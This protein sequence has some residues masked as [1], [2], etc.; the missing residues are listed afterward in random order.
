MSAAGAAPDHGDPGGAAPTALLFTGG[1]IYPMASPALE[2]GGALLTRG[3]RV[4][5]VG[6]AEGLDADLARG[7]APVELG[8]RALLPGLCDGHMHLTLAAAE[9]G[10][11]SL[12]G[13]R[14]RAELAREVRQAAAPAPAGSWIRGQGWEQRLLGQDTASLRAALDAA[15]PDHPVF[16]ASKD[17]HSVLLNSPALAALLSGARLPDKC[18]VERGQGGEPTGLVLE[19][20]FALRELLLPPASEAELLSNLPDYLGYLHA[21]GITTAHSQEEPSGARLLRRYLDAAPVSGRA[22]VLYNLLLQEPEE[23][24]DGA[25]QRRKDALPG[26][27]APG[28]YKLFLDGTFGTLS[29]AVSAPYASGGGRG[30]LLMSDEELGRWLTAIRESGGYA[31]MHAIGDRAVDQAL[32]GVR[33]LGWPAGTV[34]R[35]EHAQLV[36][37]AVLARTGALRGVAISGQPSH[38]WGDREIVARHLTGEPARRYAYAFASVLKAGAEL[39]FGSDAPVEQPDPWRGVQAALTRMDGHQDQGPWIPG[40]RLTLEQC[41]RAHTTGPARL[42]GAQLGCGALRAG[43]LADLVVL[44]PDPFEVAR[45]DPGA[46]GARVRAAETYLSGVRVHPR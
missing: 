16:L 22:R 25:R 32:Q 4:A 41:L 30:L 11:L 44:E 7:A 13:V 17:M 23:V 5:Y 14:N 8:G 15:A 10:A 46:L 28:G 6:P 3:D 39:I 37:G 33:H 21:C 26:W 24:P 38:M 43:G 29:A 45:Q 34:H 36:S 18:V 12:F 1:P 42:H 35:V 40:E 27:L 2:R 20:I 9:H 31:V 19:E